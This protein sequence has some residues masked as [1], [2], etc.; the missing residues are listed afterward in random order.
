MIQRIRT[1]NLL[2]GIKFSIAEFVIIALLISPFA[3]YY[4]LHAKV[5]FAL[6]SVGLILNCLTVAALGLRQ[7]FGKE[8]GI[9]WRGLLD[10]KERARIDRAN[11]HLLKDTLL[12]TVTA[13]VPYVMIGLVA[14]ELL[15]R[16]KDG[17]L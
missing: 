2:N 15:T 4:I 6:V 7:W 8:Q 16:S 14:Y 12:I 1:H 5:I 17:R 11:P 13:L 9:G 10:K 3:I